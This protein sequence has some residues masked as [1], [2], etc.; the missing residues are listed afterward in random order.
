M[1]NFNNFGL[2]FITSANDSENEMILLAPHGI[3]AKEPSV[4]GL[5]EIVKM[6]ALVRLL[7]DSYVFRMSTLFG[8]KDALS[9]TQKAVIQYYICSSD[10]VIL[11]YKGLIGRSVRDV[12]RDLQQGID[13]LRKEVRPDTVIKLPTLAEVGNRDSYMLV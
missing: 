2:L 10:F 1:E 12:P 9:I 8:V 3:S 13:E 5:P 7:K 11:K 6:L 4:K